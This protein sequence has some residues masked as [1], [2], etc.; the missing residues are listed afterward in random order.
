M[1]IIDQNW[2]Q[3]VKDKYPEYFTGKKVLEI[4]SL[5]VNG[6]TWDFFDDC[7]MTGVDWIAGN[8]VTVQKIAHDT[9]FEDDTFDVLVSFNALEHDPYFDRSLTHNMK[10]LKPGGLIIL[11]WAHKNS[12]KHGP[13]FDPSLQG[14]YYPKTIEEIK[15][16]LAPLNVTI[17]DEIHETNPYIGVMAGIVAK[18]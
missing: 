17:L 5:D 13:E 10:A 18:K 15:A 9:E 11:R 1:N 3:K 14:G 12:S 7:E 2:M 16:V 4:G 6:H 8:N